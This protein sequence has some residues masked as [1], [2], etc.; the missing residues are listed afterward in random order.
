MGEHHTKREGQL[1]RRSS[2][3]AKKSP[4]SEYMFVCVCVYTQRVNSCYSTQRNE[5]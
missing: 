5:G 1:A 4:L 3:M 2:S